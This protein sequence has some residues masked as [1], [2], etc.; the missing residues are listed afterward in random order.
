MKKL[1]GYSWR[2][3][4]SGVTGFGFIAQEVQN[5]FPEAVTNFGQAMTLEDGTEVKNVLSVDTTGVSAALHHEAIL[6]ILKRVEALENQQF[7]ND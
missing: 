2:R 5:V 4:D 6:A 3:L 1:R 7:Q